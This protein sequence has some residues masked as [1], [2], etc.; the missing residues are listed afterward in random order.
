MSKGTGRSMS[1][2]SICPRCKGGGEKVE[3]DWGLAI[4]SFG[5]TA[6]VDASIP[7][8]CNLCKGR[9]YLVGFAPTHNPE[10]PPKGA[11]R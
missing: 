6:L 8:T 11:E 9:G 5:F 10:Q 4:L 7:E 2:K 1:T 3:V